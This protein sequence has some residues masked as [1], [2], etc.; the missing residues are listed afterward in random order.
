MSNL[1][2]GDWFGLLFAVAVLYVLVRPQSKAADLVSA[3]FK[4]MRALV[5][6]AADLA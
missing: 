3:L 6:R 4:L 1:R 5:R 2:T